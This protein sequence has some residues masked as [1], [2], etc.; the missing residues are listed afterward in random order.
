MLIVR[1]IW[2]R[3]WTHP[4]K[5]DFERE[6][7]TRFAKTGFFHESI[8]PWPLEYPTGGISNFTKING[9]F[10]LS[11][12]VTVICVKLILGVSDTGDI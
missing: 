4:E 1:L 2:K 5:W 10:C 11:P 12:G 8:F 3:S 9:Y 6:S 7:D